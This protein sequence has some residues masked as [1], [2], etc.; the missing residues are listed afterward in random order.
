MTDVKRGDRVRAVVEGTV[1]YIGE[2]LVEVAVGAVYPAAVLKSMLEILPLPEPPHGSVVIDKDG[3]AWQNDD[4]F[5]DLAG[6]VV[7]DDENDHGP[8]YH[9]KWAD[10]TKRY[11]PLKVVHTPA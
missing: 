5:W 11:G 10:I 3:D 7:Y 8:H 6:A 2:D 4:G 1:T 9:Q